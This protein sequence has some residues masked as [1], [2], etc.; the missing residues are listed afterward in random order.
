MNKF[1]SYSIN[2]PSKQ[3]RRGT[4]PELVFCTS[5]STLYLWNRATESWETQQVSQPDTEANTAVDFS[6][7]IPFTKAYSF[8]TAHAVSGDIEFTPNFTGAMPGAVTMVR[9]LADG[10]H[11]VTFPGLRKSTRRP[12]MITGKIFSTTWFSFT[13]AFV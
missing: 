11:A 10:T 4:D 6:A 12:G 9:L 3:P 1:L 8:M 5:N 7:Q 13:T 2:P